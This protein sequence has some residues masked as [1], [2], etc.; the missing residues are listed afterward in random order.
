MRPER[1]PDIQVGLWYGSGTS[2]YPDEYLH[3]ALGL[4]VHYHDEGMGWIRIDN[5]R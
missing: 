1:A 4:A 3:E 2:A 5:N